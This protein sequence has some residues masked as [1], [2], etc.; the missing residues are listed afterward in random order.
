LQSLNEELHTVNAELN[1]KVDALDRANNDLTN[2]FESTRVPTLF[3][4]RDLVIRSYTPAVSTL[5]NILPSD[6]G[7]PITDLSGRIS[8]PTLIADVKQVLT[9][10]KTLERAIEHHEAASFYLLRI[11]PYRD[12]VQSIDGVVL[13]FIDVT[14]LTRAEE[15]QRVLVAE[16]NHRVKNM[17]AIV[18]SI[19]EQ[20]YRTTPDPLEFKTR[21]IQRTQ[22]MA[23]SYELLSR[24]NWT[25]T[26]I[27]D[28]V[29]PQ[30]AP[31]GLDRFD[32]EGPPLRLTPKQALSLGMVLHELATNAAKYGA[33]SVDGGRVKL[34]W[35]DRRNGPTS[36][37]VLTWREV[38]GPAPAGKPRPGFGLR[39]IE[40]ET[41]Y[42]MGGSAKLEFAPAGLTAVLSF[43]RAN[44]PK[45]VEQR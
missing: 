3:L 36:E 18:I 16:L 41:T 33:L 20:T 38:D 17:L 14:S 43:P 44:G 7:R 9:D 26:L 1:S 42:N 29:T 21:F 11:A 2:L 31:F 35:E 4:D 45:L 6:R 19:A 32:V 5:F 23:K 12:S 28:L 37:A 39:L 34:H 27:R 15:H 10:G 13:S 30:L 22:A 8:L 24:E 25:D 40:Q